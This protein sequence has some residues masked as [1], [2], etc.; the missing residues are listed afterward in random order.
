MQPWVAERIVVEGTWVEISIRMRY[1]TWI[2][3]CDQHGLN[4]V[5]VYI[6][7][8][9]CCSR[10]TCWRGNRKVMVA[11]AECRKRPGITCTQ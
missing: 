4:S 3:A 7:S 6:R 10:T 5:L 9:G 2:L 11:L 8:A 1:V